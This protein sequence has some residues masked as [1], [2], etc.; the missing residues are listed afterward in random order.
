MW[1][2]LLTC[3]THPDRPAAS[4][5]LA[6]LFV[7]D[8]RRRARIDGPQTGL[9]DGIRM[10]RSSGRRGLGRAADPRCFVCRRPYPIPD[11]GAIRARPDIRE[12]GAPEEAV[13][14]AGV[15]TGTGTGAGGD[16][17]V[18]AAAGRDA[19]AD[20]ADDPLWMASPERPAVFVLVH[21]EDERPVG[22]EGEALVHVPGT[23]VVSLIPVDAVAPFAGVLQGVGY[24]L[25][26]CEE[27]GTRAPGGSLT[28]VP[29]T[30]SGS[31]VPNRAA[32]R[33]GRRRRAA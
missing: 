9:A 8:R 33:Q 10:L 26:R 15:S 29:V 32:R 30:G 12:I 25:P 21:V 20:A 14:G 5:S 31:G 2:G 24:G 17:G 18:G 28:E 1:I 4:Q 3:G 22:S 19:G 7:W 23:D 6:T 11:P 16:T 27:C 13:S